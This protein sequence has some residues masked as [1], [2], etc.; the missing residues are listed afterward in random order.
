VQVQFGPVTA[1]NA[2]AHVAP[3]SVTA[4]IEVKATVPENA[5]TGNAVPLAISFGGYATAPGPTVA[6]Q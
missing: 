6:I 5:P 2:T 4:V 3:H 1:S